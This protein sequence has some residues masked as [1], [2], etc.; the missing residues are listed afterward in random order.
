MLFCHWH[1]YWNEKGGQKWEVIG[2]FRIIQTFRIHTWSELWVGECYLQGSTLLAKYKTKQNKKTNSVSW[3]GYKRVQKAR[4]E[5][6]ILTFPLPPTPPAC[7]ICVALSSIPC[8]G[9]CSFTLS[10]WGLCLP[11]LSASRSLCV[12]WQQSRNLSSIK[13]LY[14]ELLSDSARNLEFFSTQIPWL[15]LSP[16]PRNHNPIY[17]KPCDPRTTFGTATLPTW[18]PNK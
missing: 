9:S 11:Q 7:P 8:H 2:L 12:C 15:P 6:T 14:L 5:G 13:M 17:I 3:L 4:G 10:W 1:I 18:A 16:I